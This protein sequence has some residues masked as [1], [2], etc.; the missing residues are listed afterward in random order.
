[1]ADQD[2]RCACFRI[3]TGVK[4]M[5]NECIYIVERDPV[6]LKYKV[7]EKS[8]REKKV[9]VYVEAF[10]PD[11]K[12][13]KEMLEHARGAERTMAEF[14]E[15][16]SDITRC[17]MNV[18]KISPPIFS[19]IMQENNI[20]RPLKAEIIQALLNNAADRV[21]VNPENL[22]RANGLIE[23]GRDGGPDVVQ[24]PFTGYSRA[25]N[26]RATRDIVKELNR[27]GYKTFPNDYRLFGYYGKNAPLKDKTDNKYDLA[28]DLNEVIRVE[29][30]NRKQFLWGLVIDGTEP[31]DAGDGVLLFWDQTDRIY[32]DTGENVDDDV[33]DNNGKLLLRALIDPVSLKGMKISFVCQNRFWYNMAVQSLKDIEVDNYMS[34]VL[35]Q[36]REVVSEFTLMNKKGKRPKCI[37]GEFRE[38]D[39][40][41]RYQ[42]DCLEIEGKFE[43]FLFPPLGY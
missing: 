35:I 28:M 8:G 41:D 4:N 7:T 6:S 11:R 5:N 37:L 1:M 36:D 13:L 38:E 10:S 17:K 30:K 9:T 21:F 16:C 34:V 2:Q 39:N 27:K 14:A 3:L 23:E 42:D 15:A 18:K 25:K 20:K 29:D 40:E 31:E 12:Q 24:T 43:H 19:R 26:E 32:N 33:I 22:M